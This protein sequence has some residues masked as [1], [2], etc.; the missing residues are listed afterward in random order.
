MEIVSGA[1]ALGGDKDVRVH[2]LA[3]LDA[4]FGRFG[5]PDATAE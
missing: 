4:M 5:E 3:N 1:E 2:E